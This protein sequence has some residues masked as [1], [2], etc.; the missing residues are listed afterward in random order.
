MLL[1]MDAARIVRLAQLF[2]ADDFATLRATAA[3]IR[4]RRFE[5]VE[6]VEF[7]DFHRH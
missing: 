4:W 2:D 3:V 1:F 6:N 5:N 7:D